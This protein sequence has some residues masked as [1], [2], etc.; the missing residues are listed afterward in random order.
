VSTKLKSLLVLESFFYGISSA[1]TTGILFVYIVSIGGG[2]GGIS[3]VVGVAGVTKLLIHLIL[4]KFPGILLTKV[5]FNFIIQHAV[6]RILFLFIPFTQDVGMIALIYACA[7]ATPTTAFTNL[8]IFGSL[9]EGE[10]KDVTAK[11]TAALGFSSIIGYGTA[12]FLLAFMPP[13]VKF[14]YIFVLGAGIGLLATL[15]VSMME[16][17][18]LEKVEIP[19]SIKQPE[20]LFSTSTYFVAIFAGNYLLTVVWV[21]Y[22]MEYLN[23]PDYLAISMYLATMLTSVVASVICKAWSFKRLRYSVGL[24]ASTPILALVTPFAII[25]PLLSSFSSFTYTASNFIGNFLFAGYNRWLGAIKSSMLIVIIMCLA[26]I[27]IS[28]MSTLVNGNYF[29]LF[30]IVFG[31]K[32]FAFVLSATTIPEVAAI[33]EDEA[34]TNSYLMYNKTLA[35]HYASL[36]FSKE[37]L[38]L[39]AR[40]ITLTISFLALY[41]IYRLLY[42]LIH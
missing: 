21:P 9:S 23:A 31:I 12:I 7:A 28:P 17:S 35:V 29:Y 13:D 5:K 37:T 2:V 26:N 32:L 39:V 16:L 33:P 19:K 6:D 36:R 30:L 14:L 18:H 10:I 40:L 42:I 22:V 41:I 1:L 11:R 34:L 27:L 15:T 20:R 3:L 38:L 24:D 8:A 25:H 4:Y